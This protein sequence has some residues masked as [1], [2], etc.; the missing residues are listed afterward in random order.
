M[1]QG[2]L[3]PPGIPKLNPSRDWVL[4]LGCL[5]V[6]ILLSI[7][8]NGWY[9]FFELIKESAPQAATEQAGVDTSSLERVQA[10]FD[11]RATEEGRYR[12]EYR[13]VDPSR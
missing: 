1:M 11:A 9:F 10:L 3:K 2:F 5:I 13:F 8:W 4:L 12:S 6:G 7:L